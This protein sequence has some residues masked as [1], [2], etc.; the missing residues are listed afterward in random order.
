M[1]TTQRLR[2]WTVALGAAGTLATGSVG[3]AQ[4]R[5]TAVILAAVLLLIG[6]G[7]FGDEQ[8]GGE[9]RAGLWV[10]GTDGTEERLVVGADPSQPPH[11]PRTVRPSPTSARNPGLPMRTS[12]TVCSSSGARAPPRSTSTGAVEGDCLGLASSPDG[13]RV[14]AL[15]RGAGDMSQLWSI[16]ADGTGAAL[17]AEVGPLGHVGVF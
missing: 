1:C 3:G 9:P 13:A 16:A 14:A 6:C 17:L 11:G 8:R 15:C 2:P 7:P 10:V 12:S 4:G 5:M